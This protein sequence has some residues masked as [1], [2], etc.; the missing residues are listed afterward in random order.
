ME[1]R[2]LLALSLSFLIL[3]FYPVLLQK[4]YPEYGKTKSQAINQKTSS[5]TASPAASSVPLVTRLRE[6][7]EKDNVVYSNKKLRL[8][9]NQQGGGVR[10]LAFHDFIDSE[11][12]APL[13]LISNKTTQGATFS[14][15]TLSPVAE[16]DASRS[17]LSVEPAAVRSTSTLADGNIS[18]EKNYRFRDSGYAADLSVTFTNTSSKPT[19][20]QYQLFAGPSVQPRHSIDS[21]YVEANFFTSNENKNKLQHIKESKAGKKVDSAAAIDWVATKDR[22]FS[23]IV[24]PKQAKEFGG[25]VEGLGDNRFMASVVSP[26]SVLSPGASV[27][28]EFLVYMGPNDMDELVPLGLSEI[29]NFGKLDFFGKVCIGG[30]ELLQKIFKN[31]GLAIIALTLIINGFL[32]PFTRHSFLSMRRMQELQP[33]V[34]QLREKYKDN[35]QRMNKE[36]M[37]LYQ[38][39]KVNPLGGCLP[40]LLQ[41]PVFIALYVATAK[42]PKLITPEFL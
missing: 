23:I 30:L 14:I 18:V 29:V 34:N 5:G 35:S 12:R 27:T 19:N 22:H 2:V 21:Q 11:T 24:K 8:V 25:R 32:F 7:S 3:G 37:E 1:K 26:T 10:E 36:M 9:Y 31:Y 39:N 17:V 15:A 33:Q 20:L 38:K 6:Y 41:M 42:S 4:L 40:L 28:H 13:K 16:A